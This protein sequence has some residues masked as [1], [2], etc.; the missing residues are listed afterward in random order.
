MNRTVL[1]HPEVLPNYQ[2]EIIGEMVERQTTQIRRMV[3]KK[4]I[5]LD[6]LIF[7]PQDCYEIMIAA[8]ELEDLNCCLSSFLSYFA[9]EFRG[10]PEPYSADGIM[11]SALVHLVRIETDLFAY[12]WLPEQ[13]R[14]L[15]LSIN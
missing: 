11:F 13:V 8:V 12:G 5:R 9:A 2:I 14:A 15:G 1:M 7:Y 4:I 6:S 10:A 3:A